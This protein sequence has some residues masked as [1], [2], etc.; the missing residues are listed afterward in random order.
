MRGYDKYL[1]AIVGCLLY[2][3]A[4]ASHEPAPLLIDWEN[5][6]NSVILMLDFSDPVLDPL[7]PGLPAPLPQYT[8]EAAVLEAINSHEATATIFF[9]APGAARHLISDRLSPDLRA[10]LDPSDPQELLQR[11]LVL[12]YPSVE[13]A[14]LA[15]AALAGKPG[16]AYATIDSYW[17]FPEDPPL[18]QAY[19]VF[20]Q[21]LYL[22][23]PCVDGD[24]LNVAI[25]VTAHIITADFL[26]VD[27]PTCSPPDLNG[28]VIGGVPGGEYR[29]RIRSRG[30]DGVRDEGEKR[31]MVK[32]VPSPVPVTAFYHSGL[33]HYFITASAAE[34]DSLL[35]GGGG[36]G[37]QSVDPGF[38][39]WPA[40]SPA[41]TAA[42][43]VCR[44]YSAL[45]N[46]HF[47]TAG[48]RECESL[49][50]PGSGWSYEGIA[51]R[52]LVPTKGSC[53]AGTVP[54]WRL[55]NDRAAAGDSNHRFIASSDTYRHMMANGW[56][57]E[58]A[59]FCSPL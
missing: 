41:P 34:R 4:L 30:G 12:T 22:G 8:G 58:G 48:P 35:A 18:P 21:S 47:Y 55:F 25:D 2:A 44:F 1:A 46:S 59:A 6:T 42:Q 24:A 38:R 10:Q 23:I 39:A 19:D 51:F 53:P 9:L 11:Y 56:I 32:T 14:V 27:Q 16:V 7:L 40:D 3:S 20:S 57:G 5:R 15:T 26:R 43:P 29:I 17:G 37:W 36:G 13:A 45:V 33:G 49:Q 52:A 54:V 50:Q 28:L 31:L